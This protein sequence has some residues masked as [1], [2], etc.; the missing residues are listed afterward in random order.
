MACALSHPSTAYLPSSPRRLLCCTPWSVGRLSLRWL[1]LPIPLGSLEELA[2]QWR[3]D[4]CSRSYWILV[5]GAVRACVAVQILPVSFPLTRESRRS[6]Y[7]ICRC[8]LAWLLEDSTHE[9]A[10][11]S[12]SSSQQNMWA[13]CNNFFML[14]T[15]SCLGPRNFPT[16]VLLLNSVGSL[17]WVI[18]NPIGS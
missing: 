13:I 5:N 11:V 4:S 7:Q 2:G 6:K 16:F 9:R 15:K 14:L 8:S 10:L 17:P 18:W 3:N 1:S 12:H